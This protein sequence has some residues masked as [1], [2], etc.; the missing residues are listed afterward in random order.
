[1]SPP[2][3]DDQPDFSGTQWDLIRAQGA[4]EDGDDQKSVK[5]EMLSGGEIAAIL[6]DEFSDDLKKRVKKNEVVAQ[7]AQTLLRRYKAMHTCKFA[8]AKISSAL[9]RFGWVFG[10]SIQSTQGGYFCRGRHIPVNAQAASRRRGG[11]K[12]KA[13]ATSGRPAVMTVARFPASRYTMCA[14]S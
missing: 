9:H 4:S 6:I 5:G 12:G 11:S 10:G 13:R 14:R 7:G 3:P 8:N 1:M 2:I